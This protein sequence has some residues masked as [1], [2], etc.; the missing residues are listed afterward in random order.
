MSFVNV[1]SSN[2]LKPGVMRGVIAGDKKVLIAN[3]EGKFYAIGNACTHMSCLLSK[4][5]LEGEN[6]IC[7]CHLSAFSI[8]TGV[9]I[10]GPAKNSEP[11]FEVKTDGSG[12]YVKV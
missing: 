12:I 9:R 7:P 2:D 4:G 1:L 11:T 5:T 8:K 10:K 6:V 3:L